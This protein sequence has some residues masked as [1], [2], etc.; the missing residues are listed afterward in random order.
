MEWKEIQFRK[1][2]DFNQVLSDSF[3]F[4]KQ[5]YKPITKLTLIY[6]LPFLVLDSVANVYFQKDVVWRLDF[7][8]NEKLITQ[9][10]PHYLRF[11]I[12]VLFEVFVQS[13]MI[14]VFYSYI[15]VYIKKGKGNFELKEV[16]QMLF[17][18]GSLV[19]TASLAFFVIV[20]FG[21]ILCVVPGI[22]FAN[23][24]SLA[25]IILIIEKKGASDAFVRSANLVRFQWLNTFG[26]NLV[27]IIIIFAANWLINF[28]FDI[29]GFG[30]DLLAKENKPD[31]IPDWFLYVTGIKIVLGMLFY[32]IPYT[33]LAFHYFSL[34]EQSKADNLPS[35]QS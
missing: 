26:V 32:I 18:N 16:T 11:F 31:N 14:A 24:L 19:I 33:F 34:D 9:L 15:E 10:S 1:K 13:L 3:Q 22:F 23:L 35:K 7:S 30:Y 20:C 12:V 29:S 2:R 17:S 21:L 8:D 6:I 28:I 5:E 4:L 27:G 25:F